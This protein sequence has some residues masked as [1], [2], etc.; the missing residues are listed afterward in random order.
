MLT[1]SFWNLHRLVWLTNANIPRDSLN[2]YGLLGSS[3][4]HVFVTFASLWNVTPLQGRI[5]LLRWIPEEWSVMSG[6]MIQ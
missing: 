1:D 2:F 3:W 5:Y 6:M 4:M